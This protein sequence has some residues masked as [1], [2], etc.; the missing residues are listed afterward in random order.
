M[1]TLETGVR[2]SYNHRKQF[3]NFTFGVFGLHPDDYVPFLNADR[4]GHTA[5]IRVTIS[6]ERLHCS[7]SRQR[8]F[9]LRAG[10][11]RPHREGGQIFPPNDP[12]KAVEVWNYEAGW[13]TRCST[14]TCVHKSTPTM[15]ISATTRQSSA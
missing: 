8:G 11:A 10:R 12:Y 13:K 3:T 1:L 4:R 6:T 9:C 5:P 15:K 7:G 14:I 2:F